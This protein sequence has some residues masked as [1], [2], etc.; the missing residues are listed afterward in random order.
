MKTFLR[1]ATGVACVAALSLTGLAPASAATYSYDDGVGDVESFTVDF[2][3]EELIGPEPA[4]GRTDS[5]V[6]RMSVTHLR[7]RLTL[8]VQLVD[9]AARSGLMQYEI[10]TPTRRYFVLQRLGKEKFAPRFL[11]VRGNGRRVAC[12]RVYRNVDRRLEFATVS[13]PRRCLGKPR[14]VRVG[15]AAIGLEAGENTFTE[16]V[17]DGLRNA[18]IQDRL[19]LSP[20]VRSR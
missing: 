6:K 14:W 2:E 5:D 9:I 20:R 12:D 17:D 16:Y 7:H 3:T 18:P 13:I 15:G 8:N 11:F 4:P 19:T 1:A 10:R